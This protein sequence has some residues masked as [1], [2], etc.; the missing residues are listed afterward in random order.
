MCHLLSGI[1]LAQNQQESATRQAAK[2]TALD[3]GFMND[4]IAYLDTTLP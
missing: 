3:H 2:F 4:A 1:R